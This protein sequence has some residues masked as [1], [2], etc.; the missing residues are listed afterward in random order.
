MDQTL[1]PSPSL[2]IASARLVIDTAAIAENWRLLAARAGPAETGAAVK[3][4]AYGLGIEPVARALARAGCRTFF[5]ATV[6]EG[7]ALR[8]I[9]PEARIFVLS[10]F[11][12]GW[13]APLIAADL[14][15][16]LASDAQMKDFHDMGRGHPFAL[17]VD[18]GMNRLGF[19]VEEAVALA[20]AGTRP[21][22]VMSHLACADEP[23]HRLN[24]QQRLAFDTI[25][26][27]FPGVEASLA[28]SAGIFFGADFRADL[29]RPGIALY[30]G[31]PLAGTP[32]PMHPVVRAEAR[33][34][35][36][37]RAAAGEPAS[38]G[39]T[40]RLTRESLLAIVG[41][42]YADGLMRALSGSGVPLRTAVAAGGHGSIAGHRVPIVGRV[43]MDLSIFDITDLPEGMVQPG[44]YLCLFGDSVSLDE[45]A[46]AA[47]T[48]SYEILTSLGVRYERR[49]V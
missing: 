30:G 15:P 4:D 34:L 13:E 45:T 48:I 25:R 33:V 37:R 1:S 49:Y 8:A 20:G 5:V 29:T 2:D 12:A 10:G 7:V 28:N 39:A 18:T 42:G 24:A 32:N 41:A 6:P 47:G 27:A 23:Q 11:W 17:N 40:H 22:M 26:K 44:D 21:V 46:A 16:V 9:Q 38:Y 43:T 36:V 19:R 31:A 35:Q 14:I 3:A